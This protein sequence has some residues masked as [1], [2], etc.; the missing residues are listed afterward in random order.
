MAEPDPERDVKDPLAGSPWSSAA[1]VGGFVRSPPNARLLAYAASERTRGGTRAVDIGCGAGRNLVP[2]AE[3]GW[4]VLGTDLSWPMVRAA[5]NR[6]SVASV[7]HGAV[8]LAPMDQVPVA[9]AAADLVV[10]HGI[11]NL[12]RT[13]DEFRA[14]VREAARVARPGAAL[15][16]FTFSRHTLPPGATPLPGEAFVYTEFSGGPQVFLTEVQLLSEL[17]AA[18]F[19][20]DPAVPLIEHNLPRPGQ[21]RVGG[22]PPVIFEAAFRR[23][24]TG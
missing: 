18:G 10:A 19:V 17:R 16:V 12:A 6:L 22:S 13:T 24:S 9:S 1:T 7:A 5:A 20:P 3:Q 4:T 11:W 21:V 2:L 14:G 23:L 15:F 8:V